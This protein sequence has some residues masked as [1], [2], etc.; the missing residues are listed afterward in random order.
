MEE[1]PDLDSSMDN[2]E[3]LMEEH[4]DLDSPMDDVEQLKGEHLQPQQSPSTDQS[5]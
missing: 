4:P 2:V 5:L 1:H 3:Q